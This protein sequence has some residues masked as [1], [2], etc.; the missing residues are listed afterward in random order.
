M[1]QKTVLTSGQKAAAEA[2]FAFLM[3]SDR[4]FMISGGPGNGKTFLMGHISKSVMTDYENACRL[5]GIKTEYDTLAFT[6]TTNKAAEVL[7][8]S[9]GAEVQTIHSFLSLKVKEN[10]K[11]GKTTLEKTNTWKT[12]SRMILF[13]DEYSMIDSALLA[14]I[15]ESL[16]VSKI[17]FVGDRAQMAPVNEKISPVDALIKPENFASL[18]QPVRNAGSPAL[19]NLCTQLRDTVETGQ[20]HPIQ[21]VPGSIEHLDGQEMMQK[22]DDYFA[23]ND[24]SARILCFTNTRVEHYNAYIREIRGLPDFIIPGDN[25]VTANT[26]SRGNSILNVE[27]ELEVLSIGNE[28]IDCGYGDLFADGV[29]VQIRHAEVKLDRGNPFTVSIPENK[30]RWLLAIKSMAAKKHWGEYFDLKNLCADLRFKSACTVYKSQG[31][32]Y[33]SVFMDIGNIGTSYDADQVARMLFVGASRAKSKVFLFGDLPH[34]Y[35]GE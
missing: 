7:E 26:Y 25:V 35:I 3:G 15:E 32:T 8:H 10:F 5:T 18:D 13:I 21:V 34:K 19:I 31:S 16:I 28:L 2:F 12:R 27:R 20:F 6:A 17:V 33:D 9:L 23:T 24:P 11:T 1:T 29:P 22:L 4:H 30:E 14:L